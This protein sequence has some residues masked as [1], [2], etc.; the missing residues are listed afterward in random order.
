MLIHADVTQFVSFGS[1]V[2]PSAHWRCYRPCAFE[3][4]CLNV[5]THQRTEAGTGQR[6]GEGRHGNRAE[7]QN[8]GIDVQWRQSL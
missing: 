1:T 4:V 5:F 2:C 6:H 3:S 7:V 8:S